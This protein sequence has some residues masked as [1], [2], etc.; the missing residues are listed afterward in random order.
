M[1]HFDVMEAV[2]P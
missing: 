1:M 2:E